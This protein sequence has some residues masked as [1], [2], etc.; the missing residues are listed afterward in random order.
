MHRS[1]DLRIRVGAAKMF[2]ITKVLI[3]A[4][5]KASLVS[6]SPETSIHL[7]KLKKDMERLSAIH[8]AIG[9]KETPW[10]ENGK[11]PYYFDAGWSKTSEGV[12]N[13][14]SDY[15]EKRGEIFAPSSHYQ[16][17]LRF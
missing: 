16:E 13:L 11:L 7:F 2:L 10:S 17:M 1:Y 14:D 9:H 5:V 6:G 12:F 3:I 4:H 8:K 15:Y